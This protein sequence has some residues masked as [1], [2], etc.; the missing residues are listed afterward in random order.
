MLLLL[1]QSSELLLKL[2]LRA[3]RI[4]YKPILNSD[5][6]ASG[7]IPVKIDE[8]LK[9]YSV[10]GAGT[11]LPTVFHRRLLQPLPLKS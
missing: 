5:F 10:F 4:G 2:S 3:S 8:H 7:V 9:N 11:A 6:Y 1:K